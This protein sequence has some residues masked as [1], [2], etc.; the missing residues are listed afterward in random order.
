[1]PTIFTDYD[2]AFYVKIASALAS[3]Q[4][5]EL[6]LKVYISD[7]FAFA[8]KS[9]DGRMP[10]KFSGEDYIDAPLERL[11]EAFRKLSDNDELIKRL[12]AFKKE[13]NFLTHRGISHCINPDGELSIADANE[14]QERLASIEQEASMLRGAIHHEAGAFVGHLYFDDVSDAAA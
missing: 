9:I 7:A 3:C 5:V 1:L 13:R 2:D 6:E 10:F 4:M 14:H 8:T 11:I 12:N